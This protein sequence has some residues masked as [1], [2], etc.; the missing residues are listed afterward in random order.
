MANK[1]NPEADKLDPKWNWFD[2]NGETIQEGPAYSFDIETNGLLPAVSKCHSLVLIN[3][4]TKELHSFS[5][6]NGDIQHGLKMLSEASIVFGHNIIGYDIPVLKHLFPDWGGIKGLVRDTLVLAKMIW[7]LDV[8]KNLDFPRWRKGSLPGQLI[9]A[10]KLE[11]WGYRLGLQKGEYSATVKELSKEY[12]KHGDL[13][14]IPEEYH[15]LATTN[16]KGEPIL[17]EWL[18]WNQPMQDYCEVDVQVTEKLLELIEGHLAGTTQAAKGIGWSSRSVELE[19]RVWEHCL[20][21]EGRGFGYDLDTAIKLTAELR[22][23]EATIENKLKEVFGTWWQPLDDPKT[24]K[25]PAQDRSEKSKDLPTVTIKRFSK[26]T[27]KELKPYVGPPQIHYSKDAPFVRI[28]RTVFNA[29]SRQHLGSR[30]QEVFGWEPLEFGGKNMDQAKVDE[31]TIKGISE[32]CLPA[33]LKELILE[34]LVV[35]KTLGQLS[36]GRKS[37]NDLVTNDGRIHGRVDP[38]GTISHRGAHKDPN[39]GQVPSVSI[40][41]IK[42]EETGKV[43][44][45]QIIKGWKGGFGAECRSLFRPGNEAFVQTGTDASGLELRLLGHYLYDYD[46]GEFATRVSTPGLDIH[47]ENSKITGLS[48]A[49]TKTT[50]YAFLYGAGNLKIGIGVGVKPEEID[51][52]AG[53]GQAKSYIHWLRRKKLPLPDKKILATIMKGQQVKKNF[54]SGITGLKDMQNDLMTEAKANGFILA[55][56]GRKLAIRKPHATL[57]QALQGGGAI[58]CKEWLIIMDDLLR[59]EGLVPDVDYGQ[60]GWIHDELQFEH[61][62]GLEQLMADTSREAMKLTGES[63]GF[64]GLLDTDSKHG[65]NWMQCH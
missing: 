37:W 9:G 21:Q 55:I 25:L 34:Y 44:D 43:I 64:K 31:T 12:T 13:S 8:L 18:E 46:D 40:K 5:S 39:L 23:S 10:H 36:D 57:N 7:P 6:K 65:K 2:A 42:D 62:P 22:N 26:K 41:E 61:R 14:Q 52:L 35:V 15:S 28:K 47:Q 19:H 20:E 16:E 60:M 1:S 49:D 51:E 29:K 30:L 17:F 4:D 45:S 56:D 33:D 53:S 32:D 27:G 3:H 63:L 11:A 50:T 38:L 58:V 54:L 59:K 24:G 48:R